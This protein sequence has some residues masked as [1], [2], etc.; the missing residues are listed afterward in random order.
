MGGFG[1]V[2]EIVSVFAIF[3]Q[4]HA[5]VVV[6]A[7]LL[8]THPMRIANE[9]GS[10]LVLHTEVDHLAGGFVPQVSNAPL[11]SSALLVLR[12]LQPLPIYAFPYSNPI[13][14]RLPP[15]QL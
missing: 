14:V 5:L 13:P 9:E 11:C 3:P 7:T 6:S 8:V 12:T 1:F 4:G 15:E 10:N 2:R